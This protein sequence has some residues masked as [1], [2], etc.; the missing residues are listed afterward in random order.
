MLRNRLNVLG[1]LNILELPRY[2]HG[3]TE[4]GAVL[5]CF[6]IVKQNPV[7]SW[8]SWTPPSWDAVTFSGGHSTREGSPVPRT[9]VGGCGVGVEAGEKGGRGHLGMLSG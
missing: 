8:R 7:L 5:S 3:Y 4:A 2:F 6:T 1:D 9:C